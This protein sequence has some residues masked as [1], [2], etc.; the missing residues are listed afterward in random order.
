MDKIIRE[1][2]K[3]KVIYIADDLHSIRML[4]S[5]IEN[6]RADRVEELIVSATVKRTDKQIESNPG[7]A[8][9]ATKFYF[10][11]NSN[12][13]TLLGLC[14]R[15]S[16]IINRYIDGDDVFSEGEED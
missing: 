11:S 14:D 2:N 9:T 15:L 10:I 16:Y 4:Q 1:E 6:I 3:D 5:L 7:Y 8:N 13:N 12:C